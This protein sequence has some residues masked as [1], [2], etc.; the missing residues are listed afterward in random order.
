MG[1]AGVGERVAGP[2]GASQ[3]APGT[4]NPRTRRTWAA[5]TREARSLDHPSREAVSEK[6]GFPGVGDLLAGVETEGKVF[7]TQS[8]TYSRPGG[9]SYSVPRGN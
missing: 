9:Q 2:L 4:L 8:M 6:E 3:G 1:D 5:L 7:Q